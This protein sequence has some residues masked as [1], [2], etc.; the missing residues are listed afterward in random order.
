MA[1]ARNS[2]LVT[3]TGTIAAVTDPR[4]RHATT[5]HPAS[6]ARHTMV[7][8]AA[9]PVAVAQADLRLPGAG[10]EQIA[11]AAHVGGFLYGLLAIRFF[12]PRRFI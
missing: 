7:H 12:A 8:A 5:V 2:A 10:G 4:R 9:R 3:I 11:W 6:K 1:N